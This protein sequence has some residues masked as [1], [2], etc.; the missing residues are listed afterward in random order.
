MVYV[1]F[2]CTYFNLL[3]MKY[4]NKAVNIIHALLVVF[5]E[6]VSLMVNILMY[7][8]NSGRED[9]VKM[10]MM[11]VLRMKYLLTS[12]KMIFSYYSNTQSW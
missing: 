9:Q 7:P 8:I 1:H 3:I 5:M 11:M 4:S 12:A 2:M 6:Y 10:M